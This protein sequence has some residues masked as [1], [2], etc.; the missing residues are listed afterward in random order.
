M[1]GDGAPATVVLGA[2]LMGVT[3]AWCLARE[4]HKVVVVDRR[5]EL[6]SETSFAN[7]GLVAPGHALT[8]ASPRAPKI[9]WKSLFRDDQAL[10]LKLKLD[11]AMWAWCWK[12]W[13]NCTSEMERRNT[14]RK[15]GLCVYS[16]RA[17]HEV[18]DQA[19]IAEADYDGIRRGLLYVYRDAASFEAGKHRMKIISDNGRAL[20]TVDAKRIVEL[21]PAL[22]GARSALAGGFYA[23][24]D[25]SGDARKFVLALAKKCVEL[26][27]EFRNETTVTGLATEKGA[28][29][30]VATDRG[31]IAAGRVVLAL[32]AFSPLLAKT[33]GIKIPV[34]PVK[35]YSVTFPIPVAMAAATRRPRSAASMRTASSPGASWATSCA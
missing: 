3:T 35:G 33:Y 34:Y 14:V 5:A 24:D 27:V 18:M 19:G 11:P 15:L 12:F 23:P 31:A 13:R 4:G 20:E 6:A 21:E 32:G 8:W 9:L 2:G 17:M 26:G 29:T 16:Q 7:A 10:K 28:V 1:S 25:E 22:A 30:S